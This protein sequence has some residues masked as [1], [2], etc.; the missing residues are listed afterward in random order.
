MSVDENTVPHSVLVSA[1]GDPVVIE[2]P[3]GAGRWIWI[4]DPRFIW[5]QN[6]NAGKSVYKA[7]NFRFISG[8]LKRNG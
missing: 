4:S 6:F 2:V 5:D 7:A 1:F 8:L 3:M